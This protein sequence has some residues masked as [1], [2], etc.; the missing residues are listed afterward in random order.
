MRV[1]VT[2]G[3]GFVGR[4]IVQHLVSLGHTVRALVRDPRRLPPPFAAT[5]ALE[6]VP[7]DLSDVRAL[8]GLVQGMNAVI[9]LV[10]IIAEHGRATFEAVHV[11]GTAAAV[12]AA[13]NAGVPRFVHMSAIG[14]RPDRS[15]TAYHRSKWEGEEIVRRSGI[16]HAIL[17]PTIINGPESEPIGRLV[18]LHRYLPLV[19]VF[20]DGSFPLQPIWIGDVAQAF[21]RAA[22][23]AEIRGTFEIGGPA[24]IAFEAFVRTIGQ[25]S[26]HPRPLVHLPLPLVRLMARAGDPLGPRAPITSDQLQMLVEGSVAPVNA[27]ETVFKVQPLGF[28][29]G[30]Q[31]FLKNRTRG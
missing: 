25:V 6:I 22:N 5:P 30:L 12:E 11:R 20:G 8:A 23:Q 7:G 2:G 16:G 9:H 19:P 18:R 24:V 27:I 31:R 10:G 4:H 14:P 17:R 15:A 26:G 13:Q 21:A 3:T 29:E 1:A 28:E